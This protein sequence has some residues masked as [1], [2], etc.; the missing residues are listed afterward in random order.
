MSFDI[1][2][3]R[4]KEHAPL[5]LQEE[6]HAIKEVYQEIALSGLARSG[7]FKHAAF[8]GGTCLRIVYKLNRFSED[9][10]F[11]LL[12]PDLSFTWK[13]FL[14]AVKEEFDGFG[15]DLEVSSTTKEHAAVKQA[16]L[17][18]S[19][20]V[21]I[22]NLADRRNKAAK[23]KVC[24]KFEVDANPPEGAHC[25]SQYLDFPF[26]FSITVHDKPSLFAGKCHA[27]LC[28]PFV[29]GRDWY[30]FLWY[31]STKTSINFPYL[32]AALTQTGHLSTDEVLTKEKFLSLLEKK[33]R[34]IDWQK[35]A[36]DVEPLL[37]S[38]AKDLIQSWSQDL[39][40]AYVE[41]LSFYLS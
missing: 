34:T 40:L 19:S 31:V 33:I 25:Q 29:K 37:R 14:K 5:T 36:L 8:Q 16:L 41:K 23:Q 3:E 30:D 15:I 32:I 13:P 24:I 6:E 4:V 18:D 28:R 7:F 35:A 26:P 21:R 1:I 2:R 38:A 22:F 12:H 20:F 17:K 9:L 39:F 10:D 11:C 27:L